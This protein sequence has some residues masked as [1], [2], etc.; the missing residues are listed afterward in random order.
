MTRTRYPSILTSTLTPAQRAERSRHNA[1]RLAAADRTIRVADDIMR[2]A[3]ERAELAAL[4]TLRDRAARRARRRQ[5]FRDMAES[6][7]YAAAIAPVV[8]LIGGLGGLPA[9]ATSVAGIMGA[10][11]LSAVLR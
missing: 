1:L 8:C 3:T 6:A 2:A 5:M 9:V 4:A 7:L 10:A 11:I